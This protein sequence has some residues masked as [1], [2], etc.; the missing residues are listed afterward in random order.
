MTEGEMIAGFERK[1][2]W[3]TKN[4]PRLTNPATV[5]EALVKAY[6]IGFQAGRDHG[7]DVF[8]DLGKMF[9]EDR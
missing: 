8:G 5:K 9:S 7:R 3:L 6:G 1:N 2:P 4:N